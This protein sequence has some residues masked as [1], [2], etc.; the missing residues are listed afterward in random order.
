MFYLQLLNVLKY[1]IGWPLLY[2]PWALLVTVVALIAQPYLLSKGFS[3][4]MHV[5]VCL[6]LHLQI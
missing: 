6:R 2:T 4:E 3:S 5:H 1:V